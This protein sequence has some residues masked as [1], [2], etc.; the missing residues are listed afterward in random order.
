M[1]G[2]GIGSMNKLITRRSLGLSFAAA[3]TIL[4]MKPSF[5]SV[6]KKIA[7]MPKTL[8]NDVYQILIAEAAAAEAKKL[9]IPTER[10]ASSSDTAVQDQIDTIEALISRGEF[11][12]IVLAATD[13]HGLGNVLHKA[14]N[15]GIFVVLVDSGV[16]G[17]DY[18]TVIQTD[19]IGAAKTGGTY[20]AKLIGGKGNVV[21]LEGEP[22]G[23][24]ALERKQGF[25]QAIAASPGLKLV[26]SI[27]GHWTLPGGVE[28]TEAILAGNSDLNLI[29]ASSD[30]MGV[31][32]RQVIDR[33]AK[34]A[35]DG[36]DQKKAASLN[37]IKIVGFDGVAEGINSVWDG[38]FSADV[39]QRPAFMGQK[40]VEIAAAL[41]S[42]QKKPSDFPKRI[43]SGMT[44]VT[45]DNV[46]QYAASMGLKRA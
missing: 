34:K 5:A 46:A 41:M 11:G 40:A 19:N 10:Y 26:S 4:S 17:D 9:G 28:A 12:A 25:Q 31:G 43:D 3:A 14:K 22:G 38:R 20:G 7:I 42:G 6:P 27:V 18:V 39:A 8:I 13:S 21:I 24:T 1:N 37:S 29:L 33:A 45:P 15:A 16:V 35:A 44:L 2:Q 36:G 32:A 23:Q 30:M